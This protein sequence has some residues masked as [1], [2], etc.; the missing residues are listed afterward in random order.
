MADHTGTCSLR[1]GRST[2]KR[3]EKKN[4]KKKKKKKKKKRRMD[5]VFV[6]LLLKAT[7]LA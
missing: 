5:H 1:G 2:K 4:R 7:L 3:K 6:S